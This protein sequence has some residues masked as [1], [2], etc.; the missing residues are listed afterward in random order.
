MISQMRRP[1]IRVDLYTEEDRRREEKENAQVVSH[2]FQLFKFFLALI[3]VFM[4][5]FGL[6][7]VSKFTFL[8]SIMFVLMVALAVSWMALF[9][10]ELAQR[11]LNKHHGV[12]IGRIKWL[13]LLTS[14]VLIVLVY[15]LGSYG[16]EFLENTPSTRPVNV[17]SAPVDVSAAE[18]F[19]GDVYDRLNPG[20][21]VSQIM[22]AGGVDGK[23]LGENDL[24]VVF[25]LDR[26]GA[27][28]YVE[29]DGKT[30]TPDPR[31]PDNGMLF[32]DAKAIRITLY[33]DDGSIVKQKG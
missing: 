23:T 14:V 20:M 12:A 25:P 17:P 22:F 28:V 7:G 5:V 31:S 15:L 1:R 30:S 13:A 8:D 9:Y 29:F 33:A 6:Q 24:T 27:R 32:T 11:L 4:I 26:N 21:T 10:P 18:K 3:P 2:I 19:V 16:V